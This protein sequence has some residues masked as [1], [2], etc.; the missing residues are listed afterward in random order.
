MELNVSR[1]KYHQGTII[2]VQTPDHRH[3][4]AGDRGVR[5]KTSNRGW[6]VPGS[7]WLSKAGA[8]IYS[9]LSKNL[10]DSND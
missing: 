3:H 2:V 9:E 10:R 7:G 5:R 6:I 1:R 4:H 8:E